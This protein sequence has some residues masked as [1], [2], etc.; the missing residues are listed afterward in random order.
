ADLLLLDQ[1][2]PDTT[3]LD[4][5]KS[6]ASSHTEMPV[7]MMTAYSTVENAVEAMKLG[8]IDYINKPFNQEEVTLRVGRALEGLRLQKRLRAWSE[9]NRTDGVE[10]ILGRSEEMARVRDLVARVGASSAATVLLTGESGTGKD[11]IARAIHA[12][13]DRASAPFMNIT[14]TALPETLLESELMG[15][16]KGAFTDARQAKPGLLEL[17]DEGTVFLDE[18]G[19]LPP[20]LQ[21][22]L[23]RFVQEK[24]FR[25]VGGIRDIEVDVRIIAAT[26]RDLSKAVADGRF[27][28][29]LFHRL[30]VIKVE[31]PPLRARAEDVGLLAQH[32]ITQFNRELGKSTRGLTDDALRRLSAY[33]WPGNVRELR[34]A[35]ERAMILER[36]EWLGVEDLPD[37]V[38]SGGVIR[39]E[40][41]FHLPDGGYALESM[42]RDMVRQA[43]AR[44]A[45]NQ[46][47]AARL[48]GI[49]RDAMRY[50]MKKFEML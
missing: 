50:K 29:D 37:E 47:R 39:E 13:S 23:L 7:I 6:M 12:A 38:L 30:N 41:P 36:K 42:E 9:H 10:P 44:T 1:R 22:K 43:L 27:R 48:L 17:A 25:R 8:A 32:F 3:G 14:C 18:V 45:G 49:S 40:G 19:D 31:L 35:I 26:N 11:L 21:A 33:S 15:H 20:A 5:L 4:L 28:A 2:L 34:N 16:E 46:T 24:T